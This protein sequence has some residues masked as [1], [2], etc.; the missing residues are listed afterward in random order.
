MVTGVITRSERISAGSVVIA[1][2]AWS[3]AAGQLVGI[4]LPIQPRKGTL[5]VTAPVADDFLRCKIILSAG[6][7]DSIHAGKG[8]VSVAANIQQVKNGNLLLGSTRQFAGFD[9]S[10]EAETAGQV[11]SRCTR[12][13]PGLKQ[14]QVIRMWAGLRPSTPDLLPVIGPVRS[15]PGLYVAAGH[16][17]I[18][19][20]E[21][22]ITGKLIQQMITG[23]T[24][25]VDVKNLTPDRFQEASYGR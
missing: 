17:G 2:G 4:N 14:A 1:T 5:V 9:F 23:E 8:G 7:M 3:A 19:I 21:A 24:L 10:V 25:A 6:Y 16:E 22:P 12:Y 13:L 18:G 20:T 15:V 11:L